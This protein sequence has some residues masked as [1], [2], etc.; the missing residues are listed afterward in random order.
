[1]R[2]RI[3]YGTPCADRGKDKRDNNSIDS[4]DTGSDS[5]GWLGIR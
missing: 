4:S 1:M 5:A 2:R 3:Y